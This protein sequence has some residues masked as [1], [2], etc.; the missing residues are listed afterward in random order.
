MTLER[1]SS[2]QEFPSWTRLFLGMVCRVWGGF[3]PH[4]GEVPEQR[5]VD[6]PQP[7]HE[8]GVGQQLLVV[9]SMVWGSHGANGGTKSLRVPLKGQK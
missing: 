6:V 4:L 7:G 2:H 9:G 3:Q 5:G 8:G 1:P